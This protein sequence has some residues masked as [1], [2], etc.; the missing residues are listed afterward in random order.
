MDCFESKYIKYLSKNG[1]TWNLR[2]IKK[3]DI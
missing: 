3:G 1:K 2:K